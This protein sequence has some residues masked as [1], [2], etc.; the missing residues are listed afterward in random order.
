MK[1]ILLTLLVLLS[2]V[3]FMLPMLASSSPE[4]SHVVSATGIHLEIDFGNGTTVHYGDLEGVDVLNITESVLEVRVTWYGDLA[5]VT[6]IGN[7]TSSSTEGLWWQYW[8]NGE[9]AYHAANKYVLQDSD[10]VV[11][12]RQVSA[13]GGNTVPQTDDSLAVGV[14]SVSVIGVGFLGVLYLRKQ[15][16]I[17]ETCDS[18]TYSLLY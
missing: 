11:W 4:T 14:T 5:Y 18:D 2:V 6:A 7:V 12:K 16:R 13:V 9:L 17:T 8:V 15:R 3:G 10:E 1:R